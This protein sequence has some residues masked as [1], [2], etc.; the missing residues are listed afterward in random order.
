MSFE[1]IDWPDEYETA[2]DRE[3]RQPRSPSFGRRFWRSL[4]GQRT[5]AETWRPVTVTGDNAE[6]DVLRARVAELE[7][8]NAR[9]REELEAARR[10]RIA[11]S[12]G[13]KPAVWCWNHHP[14]HPLDCGRF[15]GHEGDHV[16]GERR[17]A[18]AESAP[19]QPARDTAD[20][21][22]K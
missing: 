20:G 6:A 3:P 19:Q 14:D 7:A 12:L 5:G 2:H 13:T 8:E 16:R 11:A 21:G 1:P 22:A 10:E 17:W 18:N 9:M 15:A 4:T